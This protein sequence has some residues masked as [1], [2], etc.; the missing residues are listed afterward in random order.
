MRCGSSLSDF[1]VAKILPCGFMYPVS[2][3]HRQIAST[4]IFFK[5]K[6]RLLPLRQ[7]H[8]LSRRVYL[9]NRRIHIQI[10]CAQLP[11]LVPSLQYSL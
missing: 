8:C 7:V 9:V 1:A 3:L 2:M 4:R 5:N 6:L 10:C 11:T